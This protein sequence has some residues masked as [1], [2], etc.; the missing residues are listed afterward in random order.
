[1]EKL[2]Q[3]LKKELK[4]REEDRVELGH[5]EGDKKDTEIRID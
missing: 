5:K 3:I 2:P 4:D 1:L